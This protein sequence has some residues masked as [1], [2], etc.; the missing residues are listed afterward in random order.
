MLNLLIW[1]R[2][3]QV[4]GCCVDGNGLPGSINIG[5]FPEELNDCQFPRKNSAA[6]VIYKSPVLLCVSICGLLDKCR[7][8]GNALYFK[9]QGQQPLT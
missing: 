8:C 6:G 1:F 5:I 3:G 4:A 9:T 2:I 7:L